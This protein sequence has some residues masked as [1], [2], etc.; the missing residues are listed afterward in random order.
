[1]ENIDSETTILRLAQAKREF[2]WKSIYLSLRLR[3]IKVCMKFL[4]AIILILMTIIS[5]C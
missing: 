4:I 2:I 3:M 5:Y 1:M